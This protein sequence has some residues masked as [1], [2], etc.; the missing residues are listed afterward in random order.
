MELKI[1]SPQ[2]SGFV[3]EIQWNNE[4][5]KTEIANKMQDF[6]TLVF[7][8]ETIKDA[9]KDRA[10]LNKLKGAFEDERKRIKKLCMNPYNTFERQVKELIALIDEPIQLIDK[11]IKELEEQKRI[12]KKG[13]ILESY[14]EHI[15]TLK[16]IL[17]FDRL[18]KPEYLNVSRSMK[19]IIEEMQGTIDRV[20]QDLDTIEG[21]G[22]KYELQIKDMY[23]RTLDLS[24]AMREKSRLEEVERALQEKAEREAALKVQEKQKAPGLV[25]LQT[26]VPKQRQDVQE[27]GSQQEGSHKETA[28]AQSRTVQQKQVFTIDF[29]VTATQEQLMQI[30]QFFNEKGIQYGPVPKKGE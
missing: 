27:T 28:L 23:I 18:F 12:E 25:P 15:G 22:S 30:K 10:N 29:R 21:F 14:E 7:T 8:E 16:G 6:R 20:N 13:Q 4:E 3:K 5:L 2:E 11:Q 26:T 17:S 1:I 9:K 24:A 19:S